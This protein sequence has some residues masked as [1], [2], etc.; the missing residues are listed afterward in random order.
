MSLGY[1][2]NSVHVYHGLVL[3]LP[4]QGEHHLRQGV[5]DPP[6]LKNHAWQRVQRAQLLENIL[7]TSFR[8]FSSRLTLGRVDTKRT[9]WQRHLSGAELLS[10]PHSAAAPPGVAQGLLALRSVQVTVGWQVELEKQHLRGTKA[11][12]AHATHTRIV[13]LE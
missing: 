7:P 11:R 2:V 13:I 12:I 8:L 6:P 9:A 4:L 1:G 10:E 3:L 5:G